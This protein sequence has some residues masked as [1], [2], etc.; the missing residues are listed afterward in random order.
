MLGF[1]VSRWW[2][3]KRYLKSPLRWYDNICYWVAYRTYDKYHIVNTGLEPRYYDKDTILL[4]ANFSILVD[5]V[6]T[7]LAWIEYCFSDRPRDFTDKLRN[8][9]PR[10]VRVLLKTPY[11]RQEGEAHLTKSLQHSLDNPEDYPE[12]HKKNYEDILE[13][14]RWWKDLRPVRP[15]PGEVV[16][17]DAFCEAKKK[18]YG[19]SDL[20]V[21]EP[22]GKVYVMKSILSEQDEEEH[23][24]LVMASFHEENKQWDEDTEMLCRLMRLRG[25]LWT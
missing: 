23:R 10:F 8:L 15:D 12:E 20:Y 24:R 21:F 11:G 7:E 2:K 4:H 18:E 3:V 9:L 5:Y 1:K 16:G 13:L 25:F 6:E 19:S 17:L 22:S 14:Y